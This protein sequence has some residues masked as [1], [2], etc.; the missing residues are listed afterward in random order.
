MA[1]AKLNATKFGL[2]AGIVTAI[3]VALTTLVGMYG[4]M[5]GFALWNALITDIY[6][7][8]GFSVSWTG[9]FL[10]AIYG[11]IDGFIATWIFVAIYNKLL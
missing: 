9:V 5:G 7:A 1:K 3:C 4:F 2:A 10:G 8:L 6:G 11:F